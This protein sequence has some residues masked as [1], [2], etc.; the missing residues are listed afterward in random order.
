MGW[1]ENVRKKLGGYGQGNR[2]KAA[3]LRGGQATKIPKTKK[4]K[5]PCG[6]DPSTGEPRS[7][8]WC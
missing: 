2:A 8:A 3:G 5:A 4:K 6:V 1:A 7:S